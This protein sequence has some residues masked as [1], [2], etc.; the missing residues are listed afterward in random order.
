MALRCCFWPDSSQS[1]L[2]VE[3]QGSHMEAMAWEEGGLYA[4][5][6]YCHQVPAAATAHTGNSSNLCSLMQLNVKRI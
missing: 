6:V 4:L 2:R 1:S 3:A 5:Q